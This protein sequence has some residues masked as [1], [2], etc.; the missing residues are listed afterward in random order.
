MN[1]INEWLKS[2][3]WGLI[4]AAVTLTSTYSVYGFRISALENRA[5]AQ[6]QKIQT[7]SD[8]SV[9]TQVALARIQTDIE[10]IKVK[11]D[12]L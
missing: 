8:G 11:V 1:S 3:L 2:N 10:Y 6:A 12:R 4:I 5:D 7:L 9:A